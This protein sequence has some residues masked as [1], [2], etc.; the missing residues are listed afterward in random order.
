[1]PCTLGGHRQ[2]RPYRAGRSVPG[3]GRPGHDRGPQ[4]PDIRHPRTL[5]ANSEQGPDRPTAVPTA[6]PAG[7]GAACPGTKGAYAAKAGKPAS[8]NARDYPFVRTCPPK[9]GGDP[10][11]WAIPARCSRPARPSRGTRVTSHARL[12]PEPGR[13]A[14]QG[15][16]GPGEFANGSPGPTIMKHPAFRPRRAHRLG[17]RTSAVARCRIAYS[18]RTRKSSEENPAGGVGSGQRCS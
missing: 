18:R 8:N 7:E 12:T 2:S 6:V 17:K 5:L 4:A 11:R 16:A 3:A 13:T 15:K 10:T 9:M 14:R 1:V